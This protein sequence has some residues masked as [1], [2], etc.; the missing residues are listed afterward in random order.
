MVVY[1]IGLLTVVEIG[2]L[3]AR[4]GLNFPVES[5][6]KVLTGFISDKKASSYI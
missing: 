3:N 5:M 6:I 1:I 2:Y 4:T